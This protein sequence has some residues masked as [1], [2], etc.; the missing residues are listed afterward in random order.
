MW[1]KN[2]FYPSL[3]QYKKKKKNSWWI[4]GLN[5]TSQTLKLLKENTERDIQDIGL[6]N[7]FLDSTLEARATTTKKRQEGLYYIKKLLHSKED[8]QQN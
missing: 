4:K 8:H 3:I 1:N 2:L 5:I 7:A 6:G